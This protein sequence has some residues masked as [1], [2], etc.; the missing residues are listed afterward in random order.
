MDD[1]SITVGTV[2]SAF[3]PPIGKYL[4]VIGEGT[5]G[6]VYRNDKGNA[7]KIIPKFTQ[8]EIRYHLMLQHSRIVSLLAI[9]EDMYSYHLTLELASGDMSGGGY[10]KGVLT[11]QRIALY[12]SQV[13]S[14]LSHIHAKSIVHCDVKGK[15]IFAFP[16]SAGVKVRVPVFFL[17]TCLVGRS[18]WNVHFNWYLQ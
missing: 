9:N 10:Y 15:N 8:K 2:K 18:W 4:N 3:P 7:V 13:I 11:E 16:L 5:E 1:N 14:A 6:V 12:T 17:L